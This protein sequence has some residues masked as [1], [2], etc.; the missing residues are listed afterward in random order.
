M[1]RVLLVRDKCFQLF[2]NIKKAP[3][4]REMK[5][6]VYIY[7]YIYKTI[8]YVRIYNQLISLV[9]SVRQ[10]PGRPG[11]SPRSRHTKD[12]QNGT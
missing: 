2:A 1:L 10:W 7:I 3:R 9:G 4:K 11:F 5:S 12:L 6:R 8:L